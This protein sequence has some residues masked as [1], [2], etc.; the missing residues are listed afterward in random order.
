MRILFLLF[1]L[2]PAIAVAGIYKYVT[3]DGRVE[4]SDQPREGAA[5]VE[6][7]PLQT[8]TPP[9]LPKIKT[10]DEI[11]TQAQAVPSYRVSIVTPENDATVRE[12]TGRVEVA[13]QVSPPLDADS[14]YTLQFLLDGQ[15][16]GQTSTSLTYTLTNVDRGTHTL[17]AKLLAPSGVS[18]AQSETITFHMRRISILFRKDSNGQPGGVQRAPRAPQMPKM[19][20]PPNPG[21]VP[22]P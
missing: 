8:Y 1:G 5:E 17:Q 12:N 19:P 7:T 2:M 6:V 20:G 9:Q 14:N 16:V 21:G 3:P 15:P 18:I 4:Y 10:T 22:T 11:K 13:L